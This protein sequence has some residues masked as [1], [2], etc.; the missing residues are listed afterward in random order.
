MITYTITADEEMVAQTDKPERAS[1]IAS[2]HAVTSDAGTIIVSWYRPSDG[3]VGY[4]A[5][6]GNHVMRP[7]NW[8]EEKRTAILHIRLTPSEKQKLVGAAR[9]LGKTASEL[10]RDIIRDV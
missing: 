7:E 1:E 8:A 3:Q 6:N 10:I 5:P 4:L 2:D 9:K